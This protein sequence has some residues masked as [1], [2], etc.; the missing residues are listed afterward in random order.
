MFDGNRGPNIQRK[1]SGNLSVTGS[2]QSP[3][4]PPKYELDAYPRFLLRC[5]V[6]KSFVLALGCVT[7]ALAG[8]CSNG[9]WFCCA[10]ADRI[11]IYSTP[12]AVNY[13]QVGGVSSP[14]GRFPEE[15]Y[16]CMQRQAACL[17]A[18]AVILNDPMSAGEPDFWQYPHTGVAIVYATS[19]L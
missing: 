5:A 14:G 13:F 10:C 1:R 9:Q 3:I 2:G 4:P 19:S 15:N 12:P 11:V 18:R 6:S 17:G 7:L 16:R 8:C